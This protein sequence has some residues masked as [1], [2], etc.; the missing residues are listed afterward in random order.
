MTTREFQK[1]G[2]RP[3]DVVKIVDIWRPYSY[4][5]WLMNRYLGTTMTVKA[6]SP[7]FVRMEEDFGQFDWY[8][9]TIAR[10]VRRRS[11]EDQEYVGY[12]PDSIDLMELY[13]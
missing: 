4:N 3:G 2:I 8:P 5:S 12:S 9:P 1:S 13:A 7:Y 11:E 6:V 10:I